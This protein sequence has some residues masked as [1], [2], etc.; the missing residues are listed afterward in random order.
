MNELFSERRT[1]QESNHR[2]R[3]LH[4]RMNLILVE[5]VHFL[6]HVSLLFHIYMRITWKLPI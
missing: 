5:S 3:V 6:R 4:R 1:R 2:L